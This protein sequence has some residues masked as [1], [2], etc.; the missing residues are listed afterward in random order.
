MYCK[1][2]Y[3]CF[4]PTDEELAVQAREYVKR[5]KRELTRQYAGLDLIPPVGNPEVILMAGPPGAGKSEF[6]QEMVELWQEDDAN[7]EKSRYVLID[8]DVIRE[9][10]DGYDGKNAEVF[11]S[12]VNL[13]VDKILDHVYDHDQNVVI[14]GTLAHMEVAKKNI[15]RALRHKRQVAII[16]VAQQPALAW[17]F[18]RKREATRKRHISEA[19]FIEA[20]INSRFNANEIKRVYANSVR[21]HIV[22]KDSFNKMKKL[23]LNV[24][25]ID[26]QIKKSYNNKELE[27]ILHGYEET[28]RQ[29]KK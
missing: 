28:I 29:A 10:F 15:D 21:L 20:F 14:D 1:L 16:Y 3:D 17:E 6:S 11:N 13:A 2:W 26:S 8:P 7:D 27:A 25:N 18:S 23:H 12:A 24:D 9:N 4:M 22:E 19:A 5:H